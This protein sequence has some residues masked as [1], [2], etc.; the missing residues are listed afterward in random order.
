[1]DTQSNIMVQTIQ[2][3]NRTGAMTRSRKQSHNGIKFTAHFYKEDLPQ[4]QTS[5][6]AY[7]ICYKASQKTAAQTY[8]LRKPRK[9]GG[10]P[11]LEFCFLL[12]HLVMN[13]SIVAATGD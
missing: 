3:D 9:V 11:L 8:Q 6:D 4:A 12:H 5:Q 7:R 13:P 2:V 10:S 1:M